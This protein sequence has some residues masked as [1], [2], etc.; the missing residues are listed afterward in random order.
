MERE[1][2]KSAEARVS[3]AFQ[4]IFT[5]LPGKGELA[6]GGMLVEAHGLSALWRAPFN[7]NEFLTVFS[8]H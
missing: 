3:R 1:A 7:A 6:A 2:G 5:R 8:T 4:L